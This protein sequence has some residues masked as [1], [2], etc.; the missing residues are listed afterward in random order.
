MAM[1]HEKSRLLNLTLKFGQFLRLAD[2][3]LFWIR[4]KETYVTSEEYGSDLEHVEAL[5]K[6]FDE[7]LK[8]SP[9]VS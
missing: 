6:K 2:D 5:Q 1:F 4:E 7:F 3:L 8:V 9:W